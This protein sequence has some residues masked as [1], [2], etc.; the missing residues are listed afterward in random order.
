VLMRPHDHNLVFLW[1]GR[2]EGD[3]IKHEENEYF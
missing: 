3:G 1:I 2:V